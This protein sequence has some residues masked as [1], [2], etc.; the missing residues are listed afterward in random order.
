MKQWMPLRSL[1]GGYSTVQLRYSEELSL[2]FHKIAHFCIGNLICA[3][4]RFMDGHFLIAKRKSIL[5]SGQL[6]DKMMSF[7]LKIY[8][9]CIF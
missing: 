8:P 3:R 2:T 5:L 9:K 4:Y 7:L 6:F 1:T